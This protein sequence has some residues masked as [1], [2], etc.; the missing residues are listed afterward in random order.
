VISTIISH[1]S[2]V[3]LAL[4]GLIFLFAPDVAM[5]LLSPGVADGP[6]WSCQLVGAAWLG[7]AA[8]N[9]LQRRAIIGGIYARPLVFANFINSFIAALTLIKVQQRGGGDGLWLLTIPI[10]VLAIAYTALL[11]RGPFDKPR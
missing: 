1:T 7:L 11:M 5:R 10:S 3:T 8:Q 4:G 2:A 9:W 6:L